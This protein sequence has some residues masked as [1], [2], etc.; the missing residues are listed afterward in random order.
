MRHT[1]P[2]QD[3]ID[4]ANKQY[5]VTMYLVRGP[6]CFGFWH[7]P[8]E[9]FGR[10]KNELPHQAKTHYKKLKQP[11]PWNCFEIDPG[12]ELTISHFDGCVEW[13]PGEG[14]RRRDDLLDGLK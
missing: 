5:E 4:E 12:C 11:V 1:T 7:T 8:R 14:A 13:S 9:A 3:V 6:H 10:A 2:L